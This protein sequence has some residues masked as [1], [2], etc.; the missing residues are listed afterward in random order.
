MAPELR[1]GRP[2][3]AFDLS[4]VEID[5]LERRQ[6]VLLPLSELYRPPIAETMA[7]ADV[8]G[9]SYPMVKRL[10]QRYRATR[11]PISLLSRRS[12]RRTGT[13][14][15]A[16]ELESIIQT[17]MVSGYAARQRPSIEYVYK[18][19]CLACKQR[20]INPPSIST[21]R[22]RFADADPEFIARRRYGKKAAQALKP[23]T[24]SARP[25][26]YPL[27]VIQ[28]DHTEADVM[29]V[30]SRHRKALGRPWVT[31]AIDL[32][33]RTIAGYYVSLEAPSATVVGLCMSNVMQDKSQILSR[34]QIRAEWPIHGKPVILHT[35]NGSDFVSKALKQGCLAHG[36]RLEH[37]PVGKA[38]YGGTIERVMGTFMR[39]IH[40]ELP[41]RTG[42]NIQNRREYDS[43]G[44]ACM[45][46]QEFDEWLVHR[47]TEYHATVH[48]SLGEP[49]LQR[50]FA[51]LAERPL[52]QGVKD[53]KTYLIDFLPIF[54][55]HI[56][57]DGF[58]LD[59]ITYYDP[60]LDYYIAR[61]R[62][63]RNGFELRRD[64]RNLR[65]VWMRKPDEPG[66]IEI[67]YRRLTNPDITLWEH[68]QSIAV[69]KEAN[70]RHIDESKIMRAAIARRELVRR[71]T[72]KSKRARRAEQRREDPGPMVGSMHS[73]PPQSQQRTRATLLE[74][75]EGEVDW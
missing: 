25:A 63:S 14:I 53:L 32:F 46:L 67:P 24:G 42:N 71:A 60:K 56:Q 54:K 33:S 57:R 29:L 16:K 61:H 58:H 73:K 40:D 26:D 9:I 44:N 75:L 72:L 41:G 62:T 43:E 18:N 1:M 17:A 64:P 27:H 50:L 2:L 35:D 65:F 4:Q 20:G 37:R 21:V 6:R 70:E 49:P 36:I 13:K 7:A 19:I 74:P 39:A 34:Y 5:V 45:T 66:Y 8:L 31:L 28:M 52:Q 59:H 69:L 15:L 10:I 68:R 3:S 51:G 12:G 22:R 48:S 47:I 30:D 23:V 38:W 11:D 55:R